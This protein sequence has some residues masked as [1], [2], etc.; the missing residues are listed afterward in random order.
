MP[1]LRARERLLRM[2]AYGRSRTHHR[3]ETADE[4]PRRHRPDPRRQATQGPVVHA[5]RR[6]DRRRSCL[7]HR[8]AARPAPALRRAGGVRS[9]PAR[10]ARR[11]GG[12]PSG[13]PDPWFVR[14]DATERPH[15]LPP[16]RDPPGVRAGDQGAHSRGLRRRDHQ[17]DQLQRRLRFG[18][19][20][21]PARACG[22]HWT[23]SS[24][25]TSGVDEP[26]RPRCVGH[27]ARRSQM[28]SC[29]IIDG[30]AT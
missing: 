3:K 12:G 6:A 21:I 24:C 4:T 27:A 22:S 16:L 30:L 25:R 20:P 29:S 11:R 28:E 23:A 19:I 13:S 7:A 17:R 9:T 10:A 1:A 8:G 15:D 5:D 2:R 26:R 18:A 14:V